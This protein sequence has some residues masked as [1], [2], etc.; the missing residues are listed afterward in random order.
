MLFYFSTIPF[1]DPHAKNTKF[2]VVMN[3]KNRPK[4]RFYLFTVTQVSY[5]HALS[6]ALLKD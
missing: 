4:S 2:I 6:F 3:A 5:A 1:D